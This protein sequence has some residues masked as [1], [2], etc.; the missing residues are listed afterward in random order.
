MIYGFAFTKRNISSY[1]LY[2]LTGLD[3]R[4][5][6]WGVKSI[7]QYCD[8]LL[9]DQPNYILGLGIYT[10][11]D[12]DKIRIE[13]S[14]SNRYRSKIIHNETELQVPINPFIQPGKLSKLTD[15]IGTSYCNYISFQIIGLINSGKLCSKYTFLHIP[16]SFD[17]QLAIAEINQ[18]LTH[19]MLEFNQSCQNPN[20]LTLGI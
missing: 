4:N 2:N 5:L 11:R 19:L 20:Q 8:I 12:K 1:T 6:L 13:Q 16:S 17:R 7:K 9:H 15:G 14:C 18:M 3:R 10:G